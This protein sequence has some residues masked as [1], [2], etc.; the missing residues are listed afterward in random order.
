MTVLRKS[1]VA[2]TTELNTRMSVICIV[3]GSS[4]H[5]PR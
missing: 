1:G 2:L 3:N 5:S 4:I